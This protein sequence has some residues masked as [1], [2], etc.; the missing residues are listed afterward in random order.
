[1]AGGFGVLQLTKRVSHEVS[2]LALPYLFNRAIE[3]YGTD[4]MR[5][6]FLCQVVISVEFLAPYL[7]GHPSS[8]AVSMPNPSE[9]L[10]T[11]T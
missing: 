4:E 3:C 6:D 8:R 10:I 11:E 1:M 9:G 5:N 2:H 7:Y